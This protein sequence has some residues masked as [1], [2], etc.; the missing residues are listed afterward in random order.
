MRTIWTRALVIA[1]AGM[2]LGLSSCILQ[3]GDLV[4]SETVSVNLEETQTTGTFTTF[5]VADQFKEVL[6]RKLQE[7]GSGKKDVKSIHMVSATFKT[8]SVKP[9]DWTVDADI[10]IAR[11]DV[12]GDPYSDGPPAGRVRRSGAIG[13][14]GQADRRGSVG[15]R[16]GGR[17]PRAAVLA[18]GRG[19]ALGL[20]PR[21]RICDPNPVDDGSDGVQGK[22]IRDLPNG[23]RCGKQA[24]VAKRAEAVAKRSADNAKPGCE[25]HPGFVVFCGYRAAASR[26]IRRRRVDF[27]PVRRRQWNLQ[28]GRRRPCS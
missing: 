18:L 7:N 4:L 3:N 8:M 25:Q 14:Q 5:T 16:C 24:E 20:G 1:M 27:V 13:A 23:R 6:E 26:A 15:R 21:E 9:H 10:N 19:P 2:M 17:R 22:G 28:R 11:Q 12:P